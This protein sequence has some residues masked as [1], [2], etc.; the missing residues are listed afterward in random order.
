MI[1]IYVILSYVAFFF[2]AVNLRVDKRNK[3]QI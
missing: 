3:N 1:L 2:M